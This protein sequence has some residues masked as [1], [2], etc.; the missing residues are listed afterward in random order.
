MF[1]KLK[2]YANRIFTLLL[3][4]LIVSCSEEIIDIDLSDYRDKIVIEGIISN[5]GDRPF[6]KISKAKYIFE[7]S[8]NQVVRN[9]DVTVSD[10]H[11]NI[12][13]M[14]ESEPGVYTDYFYGIPGRTYTLT[15]IAEGEIYTATSVMP[16]PVALDQLTFH[17][18]GQRTVEYFLVCSFQDREG[19]DDFCR[20]NFFRNGYYLESDMILYQG[21]YTD[22][23][24]IVIDNLNNYFYRLDRVDVEVISLNRNIF[25]YYSHL[26][27]AFPDDGEDDEMTDI[28]EF[29]HANPKS[30]ISNRALGFFSAQTTINYTGI[31]R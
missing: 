8:E 30:N 21:E 17:R 10:D 27:N 31:V 3:L 5:T 9:A 25:E 6:V 26:E 15:V 24:E 28:I 14:E 4:I 12:F 23:E 7:S 19:V 11:G 29:G 1:G 13:V 20:I 16:Q 2:I 18:Y 22:G